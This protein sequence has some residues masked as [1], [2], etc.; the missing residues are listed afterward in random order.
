[1]A[2]L[3]GETLEDI[4]IPANSQDVG[5][6]KADNPSPSDQ[7]GQLTIQAKDTNTAESADQI[8]MMRQAMQ[9]TD[10]STVE[11]MK[12]TPGTGKTYAAQA[13]AVE[14][15]E[16]GQATIFAMQSNERAEQEAA[17]MMERFGFQAAVIKGRNADNCTRY[18]SADAL[19]KGGHSVRHSL[20]LRCP[21]RQKC[22]KSSYLSQ[23][24]DY[25]KGRKKVAFMPV[26]SAVELLKDNKGSATLNADVLVFDEDPSRVAMQ[27]HSLT[28]KQLDNINP[29]TDQVGAVVDLLS[30]LVLS[31]QRYGKVLL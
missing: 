8:G 18:D 21:G 6:V 14:M 9:C 26:E 20:C 17:A 29:S 19:G 16:R 11:L 28:V 15:A 10:T 24:D 30:E 12:W 23:F 2:D 1:M 4:E 5:A 7:P 3:H 27:T 31:V 25:Q 22:T 13:V